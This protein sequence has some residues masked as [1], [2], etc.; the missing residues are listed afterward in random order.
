[1]RSLSSETEHD[2]LDRWSSYTID[3]DPV[4]GIGQDRL[5]AYDLSHSSA[6]KVH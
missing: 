1:M 3:V 4:A 2:A 6:A 5:Y